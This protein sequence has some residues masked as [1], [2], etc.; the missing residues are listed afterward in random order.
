MAST[1]KSVMLGG[2]IISERGLLAR[3]VPELATGEEDK[4]L[5]N[6]LRAADCSL[7]PINPEKNLQNIMDCIL[8]PK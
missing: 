7:P 3:N 2:D 6:F 5:K 1:S 8:P 4:Q